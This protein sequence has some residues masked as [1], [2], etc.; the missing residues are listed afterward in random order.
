MAPGVPGIAVLHG[1]IYV[2]STR[3]LRTQLVRLARQFGDTPTAIQFASP[4]S[5]VATA[6]WLTRKHPMDGTGQGLAS[7]LYGSQRNS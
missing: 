1:R 5:T 7:H 3:C 2:R 4:E 6:E